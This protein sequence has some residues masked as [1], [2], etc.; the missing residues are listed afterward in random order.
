MCLSHIDISLSPFLSLK[1]QW[2]NVFEDNKRKKQILESSFL[3]VRYG[4][5]K[6]H[7][8]AKYNSFSSTFR[9]YFSGSNV[10]FKHFYSVLKVILMLGSPQT[11]AWESLI[12]SILTVS[13]RDELI[14]SLYGGAGLN[15]RLLFLF[16]LSTPFTKQDQKIF[17]H[18][19]L[20]MSK[21]N[22]LSRHFTKLNYENCHKR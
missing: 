13:Q 21:K 6:L 7:L 1:K 9:D 17:L 14:R 18:L 22:Q 16:S 20:I 15:P 4:V 3:V 2:K 11:T 19:I 10:G 12:T 5:N 8:S